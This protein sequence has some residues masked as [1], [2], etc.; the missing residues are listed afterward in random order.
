MLAV[1]V[2][3]RIWQYAADTSFWL[4]EIAIAH[5]VGTRS[6]AQLLTDPLALAQVAPKGFLAVEKIATLALGSS[7]LAFRL[8]SLLCGLGALVL[9]W[10]LA[11]RAIGGRAVLVALALF[12]IAPPLIRYIARRRSNTAGTWRQ[13]SV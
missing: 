4:D 1:G 5:N 9:F 7:E 13:R 8:Y 2:V 12:A 6:L 3:L 11:T 10:R